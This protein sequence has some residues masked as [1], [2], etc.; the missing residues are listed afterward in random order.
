MTFGPV[1][2]PLTTET[3]GAAYVAALNDG[4]ELIRRHTTG[5]T[6]C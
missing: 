6:A 4:M 5:R 1:A 2:S 3:G